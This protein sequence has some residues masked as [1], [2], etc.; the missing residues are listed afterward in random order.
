MNVPAWL[1]TGVPRRQL[2][3]GLLGTT[4]LSFGGVG[5]GVVPKGRDAIA[6]A[7]HLTWMHDK[8]PVQVICTVVVF[9]A[10]V[11]LVWCW[12]Q[13]R[14]LL[15]QLSP[16]AVLMV[17]GL[18]SL[19]LLV[20]PP[21][22][23][24]DVYAYAGQGNLV[25]HH[26]DPYTYGPTA[27]TGKWVL[28]VDGIWR[29]TPAPYGPVWLW[30]S[31]RVVLLVGDHVVGAVILLRLLAVA[32]LLLV[33]WALPRLARAHGV[34]PQRALWLG[35][36]NPFVLLHGVAGAHN[37]ALMVG[38]LVAGLAVVGRTPTTRRLALA[39][40]VITIAALVKLPAVAAL[41]FLPMLLTGWGARFRGACTILATSTATAVL[42]TMATG[43]GWGWL[44]TLDAGS[45]R[46]SIFSPSTG[47]G[48][49]M[50]NVLHVFG[51]VDTP[52]VVLRV[53][54]AAGLAI[55]G[56][57]ALGLLLRA[58]RL[59]PMRAL[60]LTMVAV[61][62]LGPIVQPWYL[63][64]GLVLLAAVGGERSLLPLGALSVAL[65]LALLP[66]GRSLIRP[67]LYG[68]PVV[69]AVGFATYLVRRSTRELLEETEVPEGT[70]EVSA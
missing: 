24:G 5:A 40:V 15:G 57:V 63:L 54:L 3:G 8:G 50:G 27:L 12:W 41:G 6:E 51:L 68:A 33:A 65:C 43:L 35:L 28:R 67:P 18:W 29:S 53:V 17:A 32:G 20:T 42:L 11:L 21:L 13:L 59:G 55:G 10:M 30:L 36:A 64:W 62:A 37:D 23:S 46:L 39:T 69:A 26:I 61:V 60:G 44:H 9:I 34:E 25:A 45:A 49:F 38:L 16:R 56:V 14:H 66:N 1:H 7:L 22:F 48:L 70:V 31:G 2:L 58:H 47:I 52:A 19:P 4:L